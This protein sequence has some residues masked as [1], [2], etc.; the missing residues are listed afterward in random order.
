MFARFFRCICFLFAASTFL[1]LLFAAPARLMTPLKAVKSW[2]FQLQNVDPAEIKLSPYDLVAIDHGFDRL[3]ATPLPREVVELMRSRPVGGRRLLLAYVNVGE[4]DQ[5]RYYWQSRWTYER[6]SWLEPGTDAAA[7]SYLVKYWQPEWQ[8][9]L[10]GSADAYLDRI[11]NAGFD[12]IY[13]D[14]ADR[15]EHW[16]HTRPNAAAEM[17]GLISTLAGYARAQRNGF[18]VVPQN[19]DA[20]LSNADFLRMIDGFAREDLLYGEKGTDARNG[21]RSIL[22][23]VRRLHWV[24][25][26]GKPV[27]VVEYTNNP[28]LAASML[29]ELRQLRF[30]GYVADR[31]LKT[32]SP[33]AFGCGQ[34]DCLQ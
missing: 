3:H 18:F 7:D 1:L 21:Q 8:A 10:Y 23:S 17:I 30:I 27:F 4:A 20:L 31:A 5:S 9:I 34:P 24:L 22:D 26:A 2:A 16:K 13:V 12:G 29:R 25:A 15:F 11:L 33:P 19:G 32:L 6:P 14:G 28:Q